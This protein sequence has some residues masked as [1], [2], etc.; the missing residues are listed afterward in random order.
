MRRNT[1]YILVAAVL[2]GGC[3][4]SEGPLTSREPVEGTVGV[5]IPAEVKAETDGNTEV[6]IIMQAWTLGE[7]G[8]AGELA[9]EYVWNNRTIGNGLSGEPVRMIPGTYDILFWADRDADGSRDIYDAETLTDVKVVGRSSS[10]TETGTYVGGDDRDAFCGVLKGQ[11]FKAGTRL[12]I[13]LER[14]LARVVVTNATAL[15]AESEVS[16]TASGIPLGYNVLTAAPAAGGPEV[17]VNYGTAAN[18]STAIFTDYFFPPAIGSAISGTLTVGAQEQAI[19][20]TSDV[21]VANYTTNIT[22]NL[23]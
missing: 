18:G 17:T 2:L 4:V 13:T 23:N 8:A 21:I 16:L 10:G 1:I 3:T 20:L 11:E 12:D 6:R 14:P 15:A 9:F 19:N 5:T 22:L 7:G